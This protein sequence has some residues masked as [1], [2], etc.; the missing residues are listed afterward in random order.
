LPLLVP[1]Y[2]PE[3]P[4]APELELVLL[5]LVPLAMLKVFTWLT[6][7]NMGLGVMRTYRRSAETTAVTIK[8]A[9]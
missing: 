3:E 6:P 8:L 5:V 4:I 1:L 9:P 2:P 7:E